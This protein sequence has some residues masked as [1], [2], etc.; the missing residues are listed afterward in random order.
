MN[1][2]QYGVLQAL[3]NEI[4]KK[5]SWGKNEILILIG[6]LCAKAVDSATFGELPR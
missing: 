4:E 5:N 3:M 6:K 2:T 1:D